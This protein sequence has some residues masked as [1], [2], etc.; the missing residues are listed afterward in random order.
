MTEKEAIKLVSTNFDQI[1]GLKQLGQEEKTSAGKKYAGDFVV[2][3]GNPLRGEGSVVV[4]FQDDG[5]IGDCWPDVQ[6]AAL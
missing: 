4:S 5:K 6:G 3:D 1:L 2:W